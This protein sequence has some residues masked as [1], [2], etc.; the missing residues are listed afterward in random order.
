MRQSSSGKGEKTWL[1]WEL[2]EGRGTCNNNLRQ[3]EEQ[4]ETLGDTLA[5]VKA[6]VLADTQEKKE[7]G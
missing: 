1:H 5:K 7:K 3:A 6:K 4:V 2:G